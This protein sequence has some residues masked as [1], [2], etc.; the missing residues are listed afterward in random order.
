MSIYMSKPA[1]RFGCDGKGKDGAFLIDFLH[2]HQRSPNH[3]KKEHN[4]TTF[5]LLFCHINLFK[6]HFFK[7]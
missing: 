7:K 1:K 3:L 5:L 4:F 2:C 6:F